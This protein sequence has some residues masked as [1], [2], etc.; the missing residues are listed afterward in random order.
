[1]ARRFVVTGLLPTIQ[2]PR[3]A[4][5]M[6]KCSTF[7]GA[8]SSGFGSQHQG[9]LRQFDSIALAPGTKMVAKR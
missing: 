2:I 1:M 3:Q 4:P 9:S 5:D 7:G 6:T 8:A